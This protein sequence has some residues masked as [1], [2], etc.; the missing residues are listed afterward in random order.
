M[1]LG[2]AAALSLGGWGV[3]S[4]SKTP[5]SGPAHKSCRR[6][7]YKAGITAGVRR[8]RCEIG[9][10]WPCGHHKGTQEQR[11]MK[12][13]LRL[14][15]EDLWGPAPPQP[16]PSCGLPHAPPHT[17]LLRGAGSSNRKASGS[18]SN[19]LSVWGEPKASPKYLG[20]AW[21]WGGEG[22]EM[23][24]PALQCPLVVLLPLSDTS[25]LSFHGSPAARAADQRED[26]RRSL[27][28]PGPGLWPSSVYARFQ[29][30]ARVGD[31]EIRVWSLG[32]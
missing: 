13:G 10:V 11:E 28:M 23:P 8:G 3:G 6:A 18:V 22:V 7:T 9:G 24:L 4:G 26:R 5:T 19:P 16:A 30:T 12:R 21:G 27:V 32:S 17:F 1:V 20:L 14:R 2:S 31:H 15:P 29:P 25:P